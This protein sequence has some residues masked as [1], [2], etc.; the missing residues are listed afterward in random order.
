MILVVRLSCMVQRGFH[1]QLFTTHGM[2]AHH[3]SVR[4]PAYHAHG[5]G[6]V[7]SWV[8]P[9]F[10]TIFLSKTSCGVSCPKLDAAAALH[11]PLSIERVLKT[12]G[13]R[14]ALRFATFHKGHVHR[15][16]RKPTVL[17]QR[18]SRVHR[19]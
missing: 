5:P 13:G 3:Y 7:M 2:H 17:P 12:R 8:K 1:F 16:T 14:D 9:F 6:I 18:Y 19:T 4:G 11:R 10:R 15:T